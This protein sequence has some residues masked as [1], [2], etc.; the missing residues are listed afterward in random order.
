MKNRRDGIAEIMGKTPWIEFLTITMMSALSPNDP[1]PLELFIC[2][3]LWAELLPEAKIVGLDGSV[4]PALD[5]EVKELLPV[6]WQPTPM[7]WTPIRMFGLLLAFVLLVTLAEWLLHWRRLPKAIDVM[8]FVIYTIFSAFL[9]YAVCVRLFIVSWNNFLL[10]FN[11]LPLLLWLFFRRKRWFGK[12]YGL[13]ALALVAFMI[14]FW[15]YQSRIEWPHEFLLAVL[16]TRCI[17]RYF[18]NKK[19]WKNSKSSQAIHP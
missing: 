3:S 9:L 6:K 17:S 5:S 14:F 18:Q 10:V 15:I 11:L 8:L 1:C 4:R 2:P 16:L 13:Y 19:S 12:V 7:W